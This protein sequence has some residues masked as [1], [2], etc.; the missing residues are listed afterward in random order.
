MFIPEINA[1]KELKKFLSNRKFKKI[2]ILTGKNSYFKSGAYKIFNK[3][4]IGKNTHYYYKKFPYPNISELK[5]IIISLRNANPDLLVA[6]GGGCVL[7]YAKMANVLEIKKNLNHGII[8]S[9]SIIKK[10]YYKFLAIPT[11]AGSGAEVT[12]NS[13]IYLNKKKYSLEHEL[14]KPDFFFII[15]ELIIKAPKKIKA[16]AGFDAISQSLESIISRKSNS[17]SVSFAKKSLNLSL[18]NFS[19]HIKKPSIENTFNMALAAN[20]SGH[21]ISISKTTAPHALS[22]PFT[23]H[24]NINHGHA[25]SLTLNDFMKF[26]FL[27]KNKSNC[28]FDL[29]KRFDLIF[30]IAKVNNILEFDRFLSNL[31][32]AAGLEGDFK[33]LGIIIKK[34]YTKIMTGVNSQR[35]NNNPITICRSD[36][37]DI[38]FKKNFS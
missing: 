6:I 14:L 24:F 1:V 9:N 2:F 4:L 25:V 3:I 10:K 5:K 26:N 21:A 17:K 32:K 12:E 33:K 11:T 15:P 30:K 38:L 23:S 18:R 16:S 34:D 29:K 37:L 35:L 31:K 20:L 27:N 13:V 19:N 8:N 36:L 28:R 22:Y 7:D